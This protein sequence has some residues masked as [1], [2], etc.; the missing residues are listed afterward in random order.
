VEGGVVLVAEISGQTCGF[1]CVNAV[2]GEW[3]IENIVVAGEFLRRGVANE[4]MRG[5]IQR[6]QD[7]FAS[8]I[9]LEVRESNVAAR[10]LYRKY[11]FQDV[12]RR[13]SYYNQ[14]PEDSI[15]YALRFDR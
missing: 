13:P 4:L 8:A 3:E 15:L 2:A 12:G 5:L 6:A 9:L 11:G 10:G 1:V 7:G 14:P